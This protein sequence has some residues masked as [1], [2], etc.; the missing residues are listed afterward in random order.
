[1]KFLHLPAFVLTVLIGMLPTFAANYYVSPSGDDAHNGSFSNPWKHIAFATCGGAYACSCTTINPNPITAGDTL[2]VRGGTYLEHGIRMANT[3]TSSAWIVIKA[4]PNEKDT[5]DCQKI[6]S[7]FNVGASQTNNYV[8]ID[9]LFIKNPLQAGIRIGENHQGNH[10]VIRNCRFE[11]LVQSDNSACV[12]LSSSINTLIDNCVMIGT[13][14]TNLNICGVQIFRG[15]GSDTIINCDISHFAEGVFYKH[16]SLGNGQTVIRNNFI[17]DNNAHG[18][19]ISSDH[20]TMQNNLVVNNIGG[21]TLWEDAGGTGGSFSSILHNTV[22]HSG[23]SMLISSGGQ[24]D[25]MSGDHGATHDTVRNSVLFGNNSEMGS[26]GIWPYP[27]PGYDSIHAA[28]S[29]Y[30]CYYNTGI[31]PAKV[32]REFGQ[33]YTLAAWQAKYPAQD[34]HSIQGLPAFAN[35]S[36]TL[37]AIGDFKLL[38]GN[39]FRSASDGLDMG[40]NIDSVG[41]REERTFVIRGSAGNGRTTFSR[42]GRLTHFVLLAANRRLPLTVKD[43]IYDIRGQRLQKDQVRPGRIIFAALR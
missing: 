28:A 7:G 32:I 14:S 37:T 27:D 21:I 8:V 23:Y 31:N 38:S 40:A 33:T 20:V 10:W 9:G 41:T 18:F 5:I 26:L 29:D 17:H 13:D 6:S 1:M 24:R 4:F 2:F 12:F 39:G 3:G 43:Q 35:P 11:G 16:C 25:T 42:H 36:G 15:D 34:M 22:Y 30:N 19:W